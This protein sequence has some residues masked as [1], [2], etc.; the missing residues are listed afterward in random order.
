MS[1]ATVTYDFPVEDLWIDGRLLGYRGSVEYGEVTCTLCFPSAEFAFGDKKWPWNSTLIEGYRKNEE[2]EMVEAC[3]QVVR[4]EVDVPPSLLAR[5][6]VDQSTGVVNMDILRMV[7]NAARDFVAHYIGL[8]R[9]TT[10]QYWLLASSSRI[11]SQWDEDIR[12]SDGKRINS[13]FHTMELPAHFLQPKPSLM[14]AQHESCLASIANE[15]HPSLADT[16]LADAGYANSRV[17]PDYRICVLLAAV[18]CEVKIKDTLQVLARPEQK[19]LVDL[20][21]DKPRDVSIAA[22]FLFDSGL[23]AVCGRSM[24]EENRGL[25]KD[26]DKLFQVR[27]KVAH[28]GGQ[29]LPPDMLRGKVEIAVQAFEWLNQVIQEARSTQ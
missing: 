27:N 10:G 8:I 14:L 23:K 21:L 11:Q 4:V 13:G 18:A 24:K 12:D 2:G 19:D 1:V 25:W 5:F 7:E 3:I 17:H 9:I 6:P 16:L 15:E 22:S 28:V 20:I 29:G 26:V